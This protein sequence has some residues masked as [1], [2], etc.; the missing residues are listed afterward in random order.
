MHAPEDEANKLH[1]LKRERIRNNNKNSKSKPAF[2]S[3]VGKVKEF[4]YLRPSPTTPTSFLNTKLATNNPLTSAEKRL[5]ELLRL[6]DSNDLFSDDNDNESE[7][8]DIRN[9]DHEQ[10]K[11]VATITTASIGDAFYK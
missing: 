8:D 4:G 3:T 5:D 2:V 9:D 1:F 6:S 11:S 10:D 7:D